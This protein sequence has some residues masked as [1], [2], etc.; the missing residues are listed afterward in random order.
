MTAHE[1]G[2]KVVAHSPLGRGCLTNT[3]KNRD[4]VDEKDSRKTE[5]FDENLKLVSINRSILTR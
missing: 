5:H 3:I 2:M 1:L 4:D